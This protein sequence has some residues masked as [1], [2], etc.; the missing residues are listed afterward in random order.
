L[1]ALMASRGFLKQSRPS[2]LTPRSSSAW[3]IWSATA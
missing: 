1:P 2:I 3:S